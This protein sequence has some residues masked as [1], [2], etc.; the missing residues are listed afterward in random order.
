MKELRIIWKSL[1]WQADEVVVT[2]KNYHLLKIAFDAIKRAMESSDLYSLPLNYYDSL[3]VAL[4]DEKKEELDG[5]SVLK[6]AKILTL[7]S[8]D[9]EID[10]DICMY[11]FRTPE[12]AE[13]YDNFRA[14]TDKLLFS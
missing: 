14:Y 6:E 3:I 5:R 12:N 10:S 11:F 4:E 9:K 8:G 1:A 13:L 2:S 7:M